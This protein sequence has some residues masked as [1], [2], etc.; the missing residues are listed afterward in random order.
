MPSLLYV[1]WYSDNMKKTMAEHSFKVLLFQF[2]F[3]VISTFFLWCAGLIFYA[4]TLYKTPLPPYEKAEAIVVLTGGKNRVVE[5][6]N[7][8]EK[9]AAPILF[10]SGVHP[11]VKVSELIDLWK[12]GHQHMQCCVILGYQAGNTAGNALETSKWIK[13][14]GFKTIRLVTSDYHMPRTLLNFSLSA[15]DI[16]II[17]HPTETKE[18]KDIHWWLE[19]ENFY[20]ITREYNKFILAY[21]PSKI[22]KAIH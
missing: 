6:F 11:D 7:L 18:L 1:V 21:F 2:I 5:G 8:L 16:S 3:L 22:I 12:K 20:M 9:D 13:E 14:K 10:I 15:P 19:R 4:F 17:P